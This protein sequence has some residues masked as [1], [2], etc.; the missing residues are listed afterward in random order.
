MIKRAVNLFFIVS[1]LLLFPTMHYAE[2]ALESSL[3]LTRADKDK[4]PNA[5]PSYK[6][7]IPLPLSVTVTPKDGFLCPG[8]TL[9]LTAN[10]SGLVGGFDLVFDWTTPDGFVSKVNDNKLVVSKAGTYSVFVEEAGADNIGIGSVDVGNVLAVVN[11]SPTAGSIC[12]G[13][14]VQLT[15]NPVGLGPFTYLWTTPPSYTGPKNTKSINANA[16][17]N[18]RVTSSVSGCLITSSAVNVVENS[19]DVKTFQKDDISCNEANDGTITVSASGGSGSYKYTLLPLGISINGNTSGVVFDDLS[20]GTYSVDIS[21]N[22]LS[23]MTSTSSSLTIIDPSPFTSSTTPVNP[24]TVGGLDGKIQVSAMNGSSPYEWSLVKSGIAPM[25]GSSSSANFTIG[26]LSSGS[27]SLTTTDGNGCSD[28]NT[29]TLN[30]PSCPIILNT[31]PKD[32]ICAGTST[33]SITIEINNGTPNYTIAWNGP[34]GNDGSIDNYPSELF[35]INNLPAGDY[36]IIVIDGKECEASTEV[37]LIDPP[38]FTFEAVENSSACNG[39]SNGSIKIFNVLNGNDPYQLSWDGPGP[40]DGTVMINGDYILSGLVAGSYTLIMEDSNGCEWTVKDLVVNSQPQATVNIVGDLIW[41]SDQ[42]SGTL[43]TSPSNFIKYTWSTGAST[44]SINVANP[45]TYSV[46]VEDASGCSGSDQVTISQNPPINIE[47]ESANT[48]LQ[49]SCAGACDGS[50]NITVTGGSGTGTGFSWTGPNGFTSTAQNIGDL[51]PGQYNLTVTD[52]NDCTETFS[53]QIS[54]GTPL[55]MDLEPNDPSCLG[56]MDGQIDVSWS[57]GTPAYAVSWNGPGFNDGEESGI[58]SPGYTITGLISGNYTVTVTDEN[59]C[60]NSQIATLSNPAPFSFSAAEASPSCSGVSSGSILVNNYVNGTAPYDI[61]WSG[62]LS[63]SQNN[64]TS[65]YTITNL[66]AGNYTISVTDASGC[67]FSVSDVEVGESSEISVSIIGDLQFCSDQS[68]GTL[69]TM[70]SN[71]ITYE[72]STGSSGSDISIP[73]PGGSGASYSV[74]VTDSGGCKGSD[75]VEVTSLSELSIDLDVAASNLEISCEQ[76]CDGK[77]TINVA[78]GSTTGYVFQW[79]GPASYSSSDQNIGS[80]C[81]GTYNLTVSDSEG[82]SSVFTQSIGSVDGLIA[83]LEATPTSCTGANDG[84][85]ET[86]VSGGTGPYMY[87]WS[88]GANTMDLLDVGSDNY[89]VTVTD[90]NGCSVVESAIVGDSGDL[91]ASISAS[92]EKICAGESVELSAEGGDNYEWSTGETSSSIN[93]TPSSTSTYSVTVSATGISCTKVLTASIEVTEAPNASI[94]INETSGLTNNDGVIC[95]GSQVTLT[96]AG[97]NS[98]TWTGGVSNPLTVSPGI[99]SSTYSVTVSSGNG[100]TTIATETITVNARPNATIDLSAANQVIQ[101]PQTIESTSDPICGDLT[102]CSWTIDGVLFGSDCG[103]ITPIFDSEGQKDIELSVT[104]SCGCEDSAEASLDIASANSCLVQEFTVNNSAGVTCVGESVDLIAVNV[105]SIGCT[106]ETEKIVVLKD[107]NATDSYLLQSETITF[108]ETGTFIVRNEFSDNCGCS[109]VSERSI[110]VLESPSA[111]FASI[112][113]LSGCIGDVIEIRFDDYVEGDKVTIDGLGDEPL[114]YETGSFNLILDEPGT[115]V[116]S[117]LSVENANCESIIEGESVEVET[118]APVEVV[119]VSR[120]CNDVGD[121]FELE[122]QI[123]GGDLGSPITVASDS[124]FDFTIAGNFVFIRDLSPDENY[125]FSINRGILCD[126]EEIVVT[127]APC[128][129]GFNPG[130]AIDSFFIACQGDF[131]EL[132]SYFELS[133]SFNENTDTAFFVLHDIEEEGFL[134]NVV[135]VYPLEQEFIT[136]NFDGFVTNTKYYLSLVGVRKFELGNIDLDD[137]TSI[138]NSGIEQCLSVS[139]GLPVIWHGS[140]VEIF[141]PSIVCENAYN[142]IFISS[143]IDQG[144]T[145]IINVEGLDEENYTYDAA[146]NKLFVHFVNDLDESIPIN[147]IASNTYFD[148]IRNEMIETTCTSSEIFIVDIDRSHVAPDTSNVILWPGNIFTSTDDREEVCYR[149]G[150]TTVLADAIE[151]EYFEDGEE[152][153]YYATEDQVLGLGERRQIWVETYFCDDDVCATRNIFN[154]EFPIGSGISKDEEKNILIYPNPSDG[155]MHVRI[156]NELFGSISIEVFDLLGRQF[157]KENWSKNGV[158]LN[159]PL[160]LSSL[161]KGI[162]FVKIDLDSIY[163]ETIKISIH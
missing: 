27:Y 48:N 52:S 6:K 42:N 21:D 141:G 46:T 56:A 116:L 133:A 87:L 96:A 59:G 14:S 68:S 57:G 66:S 41:C 19:I 125:T 119:N 51:C 134:G 147:I 81:P 38:Q 24:T 15:A 137:P 97:G 120:I 88:N 36:E 72:W 144:A 40:N 23:C 146:E 86:T 64:A 3:E 148:S 162:Y 157:R 5:L 25:S 135:S 62:P 22:D 117:I 93:V 37:R 128:E 151:T 71:F 12:S 123:D 124:T 156:E 10:V 149:W 154:G 55:M 29:A 53:Q 122:I 159:K 126:P 16:G 44:P 77:I 63:G 74:T 28:T 114:V 76:D 150:R 101:E 13:E 1:I 118:F 90:G 43:S 140:D 78:G 92:S 108:L 110:E 31:L 142:E 95:E 121:L 161:P 73:N 115:Q 131:L 26:N 80:L 104:N 102:E 127:A 152:R 20:S 50:I 35:V 45:I 113:I 18:Y 160:N 70:P 163:S 129:C 2:N 60:M 79:S 99:G 32:P 138:S 153:F 47:L 155:S 82:C 54:A 61:S 65:E 34:G 105:P 89:S 49:E 136:N 91:N 107:G 58:A 69:S 94:N 158:V 9:T 132:E 145:L 4:D 130:S 112:N 7:N 143:G 17:G 98:Y 83:S 85:I 111:R 109:R 75:Q 8:G 84:S 139:A 106:V 103:A 100:C 30:N 33:G 67:S 11:I 39:S